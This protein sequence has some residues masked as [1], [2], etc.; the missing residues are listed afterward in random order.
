MMTSIWNDDDKAHSP[1]MKLLI[2]FQTIVFTAALLTVT[3]SMVGPCWP[4]RQNE[5]KVISLLVSV[6]ADVLAL[7]PDHQTLTQYQALTCIQ[8]RPRL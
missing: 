7:M 1:T 6:F 4:Q 3:H 8:T 2:T 5:I